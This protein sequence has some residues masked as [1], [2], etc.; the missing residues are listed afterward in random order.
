MVAIA[1][2]I[3]QNYVPSVS[4]TEE[5]TLSTGDTVTVEKMRMHRI[6]V[7]G[8]QMTAARARSA[9]DAKSNGQTSAQRLEG[10]I[11]VFEDWHTKG[12]FMGVSFVC[13]KLHVPT[14]NFTDSMEILLFKYVIFSAW[15]TLSA[16]KLDQPLKCCQKAS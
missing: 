16:E 8:D 1:T 13:S 6:L 11:P 12:N 4:I 10:I 9:I 3:S 15:N 5:I 2:H 14:D 7:G